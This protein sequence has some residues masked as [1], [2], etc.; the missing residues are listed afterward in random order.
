MKSNRERALK[1]EQIVE[2]QIQNYGTEEDIVLED[3]TEYTNQDLYELIKGID[4][5]T[6]NM[7]KLK[8]ALGND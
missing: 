7:R 3:I 5:V 6:S 8:K 4:S 1:L 2:D